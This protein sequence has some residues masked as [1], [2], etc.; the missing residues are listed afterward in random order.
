[1]QAD[2]V[3]HIVC[4]A[5]I[6]AISASAWVVVAADVLQAFLVG[7]YG[8]LVAGVTKEYTDHLHGSQF[9][10]ADLLATVGGGVLGAQTC[11]CALL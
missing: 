9:D 3:K 5:M 4:G 2:K 11:W 6:A 7:V 1:M 8:A 10:F